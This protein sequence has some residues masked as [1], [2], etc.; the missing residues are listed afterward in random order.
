MTGRVGEHDNHCWRHLQGP[1]RPTHRATM[2]LHIGLLGLH[3]GALRLL[4]FKF[5]VNN[6]DSLRFTFPQVIR[7]Q[8]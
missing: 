3:I 8:Q 7:C 2:A 5:N 6:D 1:T 4:V